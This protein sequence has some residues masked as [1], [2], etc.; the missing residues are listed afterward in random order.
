MIIVSA[1]D[2]K[3][4]PGM[5]M[6][7]Y[8]AWIN[9]RNARFYVID[10]GI[11]PD[12]RKKLS[13]F[14]ADHGISCQIVGVDPAFLAQLPKSVNWSPA[15]YAR[16]FIPDLLAEHDKAIYIDGDAV[17]NSDISE[18][19]QLDLGE[20]LVAGALDG[21]M[22]PAFLADIGLRADQYINSGVLVMNLALW[23]AERIAEQAIA[24]LLDRPGLEFPDQTAINLVAR[25]RVRYIDR[26][27]NFFAREYTRFPKMI[28]RI[29]HYPGP[30]KPWS[31]KRSP[32]ADVF[33]AYREVSGADIP[34]PKRG[35][36]FKTFRRT[37][38]GLLTLRPKHWRR[39]RYRLHYR[40]TFIDP[41]VAELRAKAMA[42]RAPA[43]EGSGA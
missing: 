31:N 3:F 11:S 16:L 13:A 17:V 25:D 8:S 14:C 33:D 9:N 29:I 30:D 10:A 27:F 39:L 40:S 22:T 20:D 26:K 28:P 36:Q 23:R 38:F 12:G 6:L 18:L 4:V 21:L 34:K 43:P 32:L 35:W 2:T 15:M 37:V 7:I 5:M 24:L 41:H 19:W 1:G 42:A